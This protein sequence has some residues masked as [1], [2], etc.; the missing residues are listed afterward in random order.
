MDFQRNCFIILFCFFTFGLI[1]VAY[2]FTGEVVMDSCY[3]TTRR[4][5][6]FRVTNG[7]IV[8]NVNCSMYFETPNPELY[9]VVRLNSIKL[10]KIGKSCPAFTV[11]QFSTWRE[12]PVPDELRGSEVR[13][14]A[15][16][17]ALMH[18]NCSNYLE[19]C[20]DLQFDE[21]KSPGLKIMLTYNP[22]DKARTVNRKEAF[23]VT[24]SSF[25]RGASFTCKE[26]YF[27]C[28]H[29]KY[30][31]LPE[32][33]LCDNYDN[34]FDNSDEFAYSCTGRIAGMILPTFVVMLLALIVVLAIIIWAAV[35]LIR[36]RIAN[37]NLARNEWGEVIKTSDYPPADDPGMPGSMSYPMESLPHAGSSAV[38]EDIGG[39]TSK[40]MISILKKAHKLDV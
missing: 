26:G 4:G 19:K 3:D 27:L 40:P 38:F 24:I 10:A 5:Y 12:D 2:S 8:S 37:K 7:P 36:R 14:P 13:V 32:S 30:R 29:Y 6:G 35:V 28:W 17:A 31:C 18:C 1:N 33:L 20:S 11:Y 39:S 16:P 15:D 34:C 9:F 22:D 21:T 25:M 23:D